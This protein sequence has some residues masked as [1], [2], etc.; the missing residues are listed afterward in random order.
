MKKSFVKDGSIVNQEL[1][2]VAFYGY[3]RGRFMEEVEFHSSYIDDQISK[4][5]IIVPESIADSL[6]YWNSML[7]NFALAELKYNTKKRVGG[8]FEC[9]LDDMGIEWMSAN[10]EKEIMK[11]GLQA[12]KEGY[13]AFVGYNKPADKQ[14]QKWYTDILSGQ[15]SLIDEVNN[16]IK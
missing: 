3:I 7:T 8:D 15:D 16:I 1:A 9:F 6:E 10:I 11:Y 5:E 2:N 12:H 13:K 14:A 4:N